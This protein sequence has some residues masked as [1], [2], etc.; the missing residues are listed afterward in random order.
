MIGRDEAPGEQLD[1]DE[2]MRWGPHDGM[3]GF[4]RR[5]REKD[6]SVLESGDTARR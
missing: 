4:V 3:S 2:V 1:L 5:G 6:P